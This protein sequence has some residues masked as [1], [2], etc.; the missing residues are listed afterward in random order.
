MAIRN[1]DYSK[2]INCGLCY[3]VCPMDVFGK[4]ASKVYLKYPEDCM[5]CFQCS[6]VCKVDACVVDHLR[7]QPIPIGE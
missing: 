7:A 2:C 4:F 6:L 3:D 1:I 5:T